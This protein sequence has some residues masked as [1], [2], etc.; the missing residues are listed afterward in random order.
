MRRM[1]PTEPSPDLEHLAEDIRRLF[2]DLDRT[3]HR[4]GGYGSSECT[5]PLDVFET[6]RALEVRMDVPGISPDSLRV[7]FKHGVLLIAGAK[8]PVGGAPP[9][10]TTFHLVERE[11]GR[12]ARAVRLSG[13]VD[14]ARARAR[15]VSGELRIAAPKVSE[16]RGQELRIPVEP[17]PAEPG[18]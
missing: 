2:D 5:P 4:V 3:V 6:D 8:A 16:R 18:V 7:M 14:V 11:F 10:S 12:F 13:A 9:G 17:D 1:T 15:L